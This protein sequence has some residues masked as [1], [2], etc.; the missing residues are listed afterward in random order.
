MKKIILLLCIVLQTISLQAQKSLRLV[1]RVDD[2]LSRNTSILP[3]SIVPFQEVVESKG[4]KVT[5]GVMPHRFIETLN[6]DGKLAQELIE[7]AAKGNE[8]SM[9]GWEHVCQRCGQSSHEFFCTTYNTPFSLEQ[10]EKLIQDGIDLMVEKTGIKPVS[11]IPPGHVSDDVTL[12]ALLNKGI[13]KLSTTKPAKN[14]LDELF[15]VGMDN[16]YTWALTP[17]IYEKNM[18]DALAEIRIKAEEKGYF[19]LMLHDPFIRS[20]YENGITL[21]WTAE[22][23]DSLKIEYGEHFQINTV[24]EII[25]FVQLQQ[26]SIEDKNVSQTKEFELLSNYPNPFNPSTEI[27]FSLAR[28]NLVTLSIFDIQGKLVQT[29]LNEVKSAG[30]HT[31]S[32][33]AENFPSGMYFYQIRVNGL[34]ETKKMTLIK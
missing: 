27:Q 18:H 14:V 29:V 30:L 2:I 31:L 33:T 9:H 3:R 16:E 17:A 20:G 11:F 15:N 28:T 19:M 24:S 7:S 34:S 12:R 21:K 23:I 1:L 10:Q 4:G 26:T 25:D 13:K 32:W 6:L 5:W 22:L 8:L